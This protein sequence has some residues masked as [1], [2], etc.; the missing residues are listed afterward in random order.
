MI[1]A[2]ACGTPV[3]ARPCGSVPELL[4]DGRTGFLATPWTSSSRR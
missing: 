1:E 4:D 2:M 3:I